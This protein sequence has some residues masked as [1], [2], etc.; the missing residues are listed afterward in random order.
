MQNDKSINWKTNTALF[1]V[2]Q[3]STLIGSSLVSFAVLWYV[4]LETK[5]GSIMTIFTVATMVPTFFISPFGGVWADRYNRKNLINISDGAIAL[6]SLFIAL[7][8]SFGMTSLLLLLVCALARSLGQGVQLPAVNALI[9]ELVPEQ[10]LV[11]VNSINSMI[12]SISMIGTPALSGVL[13]T[14]APIQIILFIDVATAAIG[15]SI[16][17]FLVKVPKSRPAETHSSNTGSSYFHEIRETFRYMR[18]HNFVL[19]LLIYEGITA[20]LITPCAFLTPL[21]VTRDFGAD[22]WRLTAIEIAFSVGMIVGGGTLSAWGGFKNKIFT[23]GFGIIL[24]GLATAALGI[25]TNFPLYISVMGFIGITVPLTNTPIISLLQS[26]VDSEHMGRVFSFYT[27]VSSLTMPL[28]M[29]LFGPLSDVISIDI[30]LIITGI[31][32]L[33]EVVYIAFDKTVIRSGR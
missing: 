29:V 5:S 24:T 3:A 8:F 17:Y 1:L 9:P 19:R 12:Q 20:L 31:A 26:K 7:C 30:L 18:H 23:T 28:G 21:Q 25:L 33:A 14:I 22:V 32:C 11:R 6:V 2:G 16:L 27:M 15:I 4:V 10:H 13:M